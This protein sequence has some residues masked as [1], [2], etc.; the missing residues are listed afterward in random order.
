MKV[1]VTGGGGFLGFAIV[2]QLIAEGYEVVTYSR[3]Y[4][5]ELETLGVTQFQGDISDYEMLKKALNG[6]EAVFH[7][8]AKTGVWGSYASFYQANV[9]G[10]ENV[11]KG[12]IE[13]TIPYLVYTSS[14]SV[15][16]DEGGGGADES[17]PY[18]EK[19]DAYYPA[20][21]AIAE[22]VVLKA[23]SSL[24]ATCSLR[25]HLIW[26]PKDTHYL[27]RLIDRRRKGKLWT[28]GHGNYLVDTIYIDNAARAHLQ[29]LEVMRRT[30]GIVGGKTYFL[31]QDDPIPVREFIDGLLDAGGLPPVDKSIHPKVARAAGWLLERIFRWFKIKS[32][33]PVTTFVA[34]Q[35]SSPHW[36]DISAAKRDLGY[37]P[38][39]SIKEG[40]KRLK[41]WVG[42]ANH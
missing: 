38:T 16:Y 25:P 34:K 29:A 23:N 14:P 30:P 39:I 11:I 3:R 15:V 28:L 31:S 27:P 26:G 12:C 6:C 7:V 1:L 10:T 8:A 40:M 4:Y 24:L 18:P 22:Q 36:Y 17:L 33:P 35:L 20:T 5:A 32:E 9:T 41:A 19:F 42:E 37:V 2:E 13:L 21:K